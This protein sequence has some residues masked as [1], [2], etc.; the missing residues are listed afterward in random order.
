MPR[1]NELQIVVSAEDEATAV[2]QQVQGSVENTTASITAMSAAAA[3]AGA[4][5]VAALGAATFAAAEEEAGIL[6]LKVAMDNVGLSY[7]QVSES[8]AH[9]IDQQQQKTAFADE[10]AGSSYLCRVWVRMVGALPELTC[11]LSTRC[12]SGCGQRTK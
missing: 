9:W 7:D 6:R 1:D 3:A 11:T 2:L 10:H 8:L 12:S 5:I 4:A